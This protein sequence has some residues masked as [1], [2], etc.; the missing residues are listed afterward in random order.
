[1]HIIAISVDL[2][3]RLASVGGGVDNLVHNADIRKSAG[4][5]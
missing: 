5:I 4:A 2:P 3:Q 1:M